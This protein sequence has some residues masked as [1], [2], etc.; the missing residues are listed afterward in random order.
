ML[1]HAAGPGNSQGREFDAKSDSPETGLNPTARALLGIVASAA[2]NRREVELTQ[3]RIAEMLGVSD[4]TVRRQTAV[5]QDRGLLTAKRGR[6]CV[7]FRLPDRRADDETAH[8]LTAPAECDTH[9]DRR[10]QISKMST[11]TEGVV[12]Y[13]QASYQGKYCSWL[14]HENLGLLRHSGLDQLTLKDV[15]A[16]ERNGGPATEQPTYTRAE[17]PEDAG[18]DERWRAA[19]EAWATMLAD[20]TRRAVIEGTRIVGQATEHHVTVSVKGP[21][22]IRWMSDAAHQ[23]MADQRATEA[24]GRPMAVIFTGP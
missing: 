24:W 21:R 15:R 18:D 11:Y 7:I 12:W 14:Y 13:C 1:S 23:Q 6:N 20:P 17:T 8:N 5:L 10:V 22:H 2:G 3:S 9:G 16:L 19:A 4:T